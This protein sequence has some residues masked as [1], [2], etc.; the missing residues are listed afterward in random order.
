M[1][2][3][4]NLSSFPSNRIDA[5]TMLYL[6]KQ[7]ISTLSPEELVEKYAEVRNKIKEHFRNLK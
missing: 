3:N 6:E 7:D 1:A 5:L 2:D 4:I